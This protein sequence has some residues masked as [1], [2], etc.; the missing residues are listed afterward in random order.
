M[1][2][3][4]LTIVLFGT[5]LMMISCTTAQISSVLD[6][7]NDA[8]SEDQPLT[9]GEVVR[10]LKEAL[11]VGIYNSSASA[12]KTDGYYKNDL[13]RIPF[14]PEIAEVE[15]K[16]RQLGLNKPV[17]DFILSINRAAEKAASEAADVF[18]EAIKKMTIED[19]WNILK[20]DQHAATDYLRRTTSATL[21]KK[22]RPIIQQ[23]L[24]AVDATKY[25]GTV[26]GAYN[27]IP[28]VKKVDTDLTQYVTD[29]ALGGLFTLVE[30]EEE[31]IRQ[32]PVARTTELLQRVFGAQD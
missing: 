12:S 13:I 2:M 18:I 1:T 22:Y 28:F 8:L 17:D 20:S 27:Q 9:A 7:A 21:T 11:K 16:L 6:S 32:D 14:P 10:G 3:Q 24:D 25:Y 30:K 23:S 29:L 26:V 4:N 19:A 31:Q 5:V 15:T